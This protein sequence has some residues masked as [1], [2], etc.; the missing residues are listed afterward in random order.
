M[1]DARSLMGDADAAVGADDELAA[2][3]RSDPA[4]FGLLY[5]RHRL[6][7]YRYLRARTGSDDTATELTAA[8]FERAFVAITRYRPAGA[9]FP[10][11]LLRIARNAAID[12]RRR[13]A[14]VPLPSDVPVKETSDP[15][16]LV[17]ARETSAALLAAV[18]RLPEVQR[19][20]IYLRFAARMSAREIGAVIG[21][22][23]PAA[24]KLLSRAVA[25]IRES[26]DVER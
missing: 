14:A 5:R 16:R 3:A 22:S 21:K 6:A 23:E 11:W 25:A 13:K 1:E 18:N 24:Q 20:A 4:A 17:I 12:A 2:L 7:V 10:A 8:T 9:G 15:E 19:E 26:N